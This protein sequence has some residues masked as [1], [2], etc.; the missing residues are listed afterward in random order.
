MA[1]FYGTPQEFEE[2]VQRW[3]LT[4][5]CTLGDPA[6]VLQALEVPEPVRPAEPEH[7]QPDPQAQMTYDVLVQTLRRLDSERRVL[8]VHPDRVEQTKAAVAALPIEY[9]PGLI[10]VKPSRFVKLDEM[11]CFRPPVLP[12]PRFFE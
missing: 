7:P 8:L 3:G 2:H 6:E 10:E 11:I 1:K 4:C 12:E 9:L 5:D